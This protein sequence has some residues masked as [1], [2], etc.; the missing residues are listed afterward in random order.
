ML[1]DHYSEENWKQWR[2][3]HSP[4]NA[5]RIVNHV[6]IRDYFPHDRKGVE[7]LERGLGELMAFFWQMAVN[8]QFPGGKVQVEFDGD[9]I[10][11]F[12]KAPILEE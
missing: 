1:A 5:A 4:I 2:K 8:V 3:T 12:Q 10:D 9:V 6:H 11:I 7:K